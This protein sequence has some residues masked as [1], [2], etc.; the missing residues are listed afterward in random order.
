MGVNNLGVCVAHMK[1][2]CHTKPVATS[3]Q[4]F[5]VDV[6]GAC[7]SMVQSQVNRASFELVKCLLDFGY[8]VESKDARNAGGIQQL[9]T[10]A[11]FTTTTTTTT[12]T[13]DSHQRQK[14][15]EDFF[16]TCARIFVD[17]LCSS[18][19]HCGW[20]ITART[21]LYLYV[22][23]PSP[24]IKT[25][26][27]SNHQR[28]RNS[29]CLWILS[30]KLFD[31]LAM[32]IAVYVKANVNTRSGQTPTIYHSLSQSEPA[33]EGEWKCIYG[34]YLVKIQFP[35]AGVVVFG[36]DHD[37][38]H[39]L[40]WLYA[41]SEPGKNCTSTIMYYNCVQRKD[42]VFK[43]P[44]D[45]SNIHIVRNET[46][47]IDEMDRLGVLFM[48]VGV[49]LFG[50]DYCPR[51][52]TG[53]P[54]QYSALCNYA[55]RTSLTCPAPLRENLLGLFKP[56]KLGDCLL[57]RNDALETLTELIFLGYHCANLELTLPHDHNKEYDDILSEHLVLRDQV[58][59][60]LCERIIWNLWYVSVLGVCYH[61][62]G[63]SNIVNTVSCMAFD[64][65]SGFAFRSDGLFT[66]QHEN[67][68]SLIPM[69]DPPKPAD[70]SGLQL[71]GLLKWAATK[72]MTRDYISFNVT[73]LLE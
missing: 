34:A 50:T 49:L 12:T 52:L 17:T 3:A 19:D 7:F 60:H 14:T 44:S 71:S 22:D 51:I 11:F 5:F 63:R 25:M 8:I 35:T 27:W 41:H 32:A 16:N 70:D 36:N 58:A 28:A 59:Q 65:K 57:E 54:A 13:T 56:W 20:T 10:E 40:M 73:R 24:K 1:N 6:I 29:G 15:P 37:I 26:P 2:C 69:D 62:S 45:H 31:A 21:T 64:T 67:R 66:R 4:Y 39:A 23:G 33:V 48:C 46:T 9:S 42:F 72:K 55:M 18:V 47:S 61:N 30:R 53:T 43:M 68:D 38:T